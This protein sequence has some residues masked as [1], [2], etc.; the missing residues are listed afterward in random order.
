MMRCARTVMRTWSSMRAS[1]MPLAYIVGRREFYS[2][3]LEVSPEVS[4]SAPGDRDRGDRRAR[5][6]GV[7]GGGEGARSRHRI[8][9]DRA[10]DRRQRTSN[11]R[12]R[13]RHFHRGARG[14]GQQLT[15][16]HGL[17]SRRRISPCRLLATCST[18]ATPLRP[19]RSDCRQ[20]ALHR[21]YAKSSRLRRKSAISSRDWRSPAAPT[22]STFIGASPLARGRHL[23][24][25]GA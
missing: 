9:R 21:R 8:R 25:T 16:D 17:D 2:L 5:G 7:A 19:L 18:V 14:R 24:P 20:S 15:T 6:P 22:A 13:Y 12:D 3:E 4:D 23:T 10:R 11:A 1:R